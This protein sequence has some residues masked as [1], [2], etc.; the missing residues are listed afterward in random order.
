MANKEKEAYWKGYSASNNHSKHTSVFEALGELVG[1]SCY[2]PPAGHKEAYTQ[3]WKDAERDRK[4][5]KPEGEISHTGSVTKMGREYQKYATTMMSKPT[6]SPFL[7][8]EGSNFRLAKLRFL[9]IE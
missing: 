5:Q 1:P 2:N 9:S 4:K 3:G 6:V 8:F 7:P